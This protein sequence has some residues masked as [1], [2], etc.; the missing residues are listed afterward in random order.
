MQREAIREGELRLEA[1]LQIATAADQRALTWGGLLVAA[2]TAALGGGIA[3]A[4]KDAPDY[5]LAFLAIF[6]AGSLTWASWGALS[7]TRPAK[8]H[9]PGNLPANWLP[10]DHQ[11]RAREEVRLKWSR[12]EQAECLQDAIA[13]NALAAE[14]RA[15][16]ML[17]SFGIAKWTIAA[18]GC[19]L[20]MILAIRASGWPPAAVEFLDQRECPPQTL[21]QCS[22]APSSRGWSGAAA[23]HHSH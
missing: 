4:T 18:G 10:D 3:L 15:R 13:A 6:F 19:L 1:Q 14:D 11:P 23:S 22:S 2:T 7:T 9:V 8:F 21:M 5:P 20:L 16:L 12:K 17:R